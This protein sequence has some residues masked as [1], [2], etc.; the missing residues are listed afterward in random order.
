MA[1]WII[2]FGK[3]Q[4]QR[5][6]NKKE[7]GDA[8]DLS[9]S[10]KI[11]WLPFWDEFF[12]QYMARNRTS[13]RVERP[14]N[15]YADFNA[16]MSSTDKISF[17][18]IVNGYPTELRLRFR[19]ILR[20]LAKGKTRVNFSTEL[21]REVIDWNDRG[22]QRQ[23]G[24]WDTIDNNIQPTAKGRN[25]AI[26]D[27]YKDRAKE[28]RTES[29]TYLHNATTV[30]NR[31]T[32]LT[33][34][35]MLITGERG[36]D[37]E[38]SVYDI[39]SKAK[40]LGIKLLR[41][42]SNVQDYVKQ[43]SPLS[44]REIN[45]VND[46]TSN[47]VLTD[48][49]IGR[50]N[51]YEQ[52][53]TGKGSVMLGVSLRGQNLVL[54]EFK[55][56]PT[57]A[58]NIGVFGET[59]SGKSYFVK[60]TITQ[61]LARDDMN[62][63]I[64]DVEGDE[65]LGLAEFVAASQEVVLINLSE[66]SG[67]YLDPVEVH[68]T[69]DRELDAVMFDISKSTTTA[70]LKAY[71]GDKILED[72]SWAE[73]MI[74]EAVNTFYRD[75]GVSATSYGTWSKT[76]GKTLFDIYPYI[77]NYYPEVKCAGWDAYQTFCE[78]TGYP[79]DMAFLSARN[80]IIAALDIYLS[81]EARNSERFAH[82]IPIDKLRTAKLVVNS[83][84]MRGKSEGQVSAI[85]MSL[86]QLTAMQ[87]SELR[88]VFSK[89]QGK[90]NFKVWEE[91][92]RW[93]DFKGSEGIL[94][95]ALSGGRKMGDINFLIINRLKGVVEDD[96]LGILESIQS[97]AIG[98]IAE[99]GV[100]EKLA[101]ALSIEHMLGEMNHIAIAREKEAKGEVYLESD[102]RSGGLLSPYSKA[103]VVGL[104][105]SEFVTMRVVLPKEISETPLFQTGVDTSRMT[106]RA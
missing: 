6:Q 75:L 64:N 51:S 8:V 57:D 101:K 85:H 43:V 90:Y 48:E 44:F 53:F 37:F 76:K 93:G 47:V 86:M 65:Y 18:Y 39:E 68:L 79:M 3:N 70:I 62:G 41:I 15:A 36:Q 46:I 89:A 9:E 21:T 103:F 29:L 13:M 55:R 96:K 35:Y 17:L 32:F 27:N 84:N 22:L 25:S 19:A 60:S 54:T 23:I 83:F 2:K 7:A 30:R 80:E 94:K 97:F 12:S 102:K 40:A 38:Q 78:N 81:N 33:K 92:Q 4:M 71:V 24:I 5:R 1:N 104:Q 73:T 95:V 31:H 59:G 16:L 34:Q 20:K 98:A 82:P 100:R 91:L 61:V 74:T 69:G 56:R 52:G 77:L 11:K 87:I 105:R 67:Q 45:S 26:F 10:D 66:G 50:F 72:T 28:L 88:S 106:K 99:A 58:E 49:I 42:T 14:Y 63:T